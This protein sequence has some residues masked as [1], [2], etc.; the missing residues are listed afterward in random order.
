M[1]NCNS[2][3]GFTINDFLAGSDQQE[4]VVFQKQKFNFLKTI[5]HDLAL[6]EK[7]EFRTEMNEF[8]FRKQDFLLRVSPNSFKNIKTQHQYQESIQYMTEMEMEVAQGNALRERYEL[9]VNYIYSKEILA[10]KEKQKILL[11]DKVTLLRRSI[12]LADFDI[13]DLIASEDEQQDNIRAILELKNTIL[14]FEKLIQRMAKSS[15]TIQIDKGKLIHVAAIKKLV[16]KINAAKAVNHP[17]LKVLYAKRYNNILEYEWEAA[18]T[19]FSLGYVQLKYSADPKDSFGKRISI[20]IGFDIPLKGI[21]RLDL[22]ELQLQIFESESQYKNAKQGLINNTYSIHQELN[23]LIQKYELVSHQLQESQA[24]FALK[25]YRKIAEA[26]P[27]ALLKLRKNTYKK[28]LLLQELE[29]KIMKTYI[30]YLN[31]A[32][33]LSQVPYKN[34]LSKNLEKF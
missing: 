22:N 17:Q 10:I 18:K 7:L 27:L 28:E 12:A 33:L 21:N 19:K 31:Y 26:P 3:T 15:Q 32:G 20:G 8:D 4:S 9:L 30:E 11:K 16:E 5:S 1:A 34:Y 13:L 14:T 6:I 29:L 23:N 25:E 2:Q 24:E